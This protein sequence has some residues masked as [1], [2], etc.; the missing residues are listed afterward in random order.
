MDTH[1][2]PCIIDLKLYHS[3]HFPMPQDISRCGGQ[4]GV[5]SFSQGLALVPC[6]MGPDAFNAEHNPQ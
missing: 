1:E 6:H 2:V 5:A 4:L 3:I